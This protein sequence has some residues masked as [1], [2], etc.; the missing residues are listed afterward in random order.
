MVTCNYVKER[1]GGHSR[2]FSC[3][4]GPDDVVKVRYGKTMP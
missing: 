4:V 1:L 3:A 2:K